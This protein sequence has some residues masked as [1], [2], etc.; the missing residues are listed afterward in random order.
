MTQVTKE[1][2][3]QALLRIEQGGRLNRLLSIMSGGKV[4]AVQWM[5]EITGKNL[6]ASEQA[7]YVQQV[8]QQ[9]GVE[10]QFVIAPTIWQSAGILQMRD[11]SRG[12]LVTLAYAAMEDF[13]QGELQAQLQWLQ[14]MLQLNGIPVQL[15]LLAFSK[16]PDT[17]A[18]QPGMLESWQWEELLETGVQLATGQQAS[19]A[20][21]II[22]PMVAYPAWLEEI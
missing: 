17:E 18:E 3:M 10:T 12:L 8:L 11:G 14:Q 1:Q 13:Q 4:A 21:V 15:L 7:E 6:P 19:L 5:Q 16:V 22:L 20:E 2:W 9:A